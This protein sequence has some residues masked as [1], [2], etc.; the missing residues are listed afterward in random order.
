[1]GEIKEIGWRNNEPISFNAQTDFISRSQSSVH[2]THTNFHTQ[3]C[4]NDREVSTTAQPTSVSYATS[5]AIGSHDQYYN[6]N[7]PKL[8]SYQKAQMIPG[9][10]LPLV[11]DKTKLPEKKSLSLSDNESHQS[12][13]RRAC[14]VHLNEQYQIDHYLLSQ[15]RATKFLVKVRT[16]ISPGRYMTKLELHCS[17]YICIDSYVTVVHQ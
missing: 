1:M 7:F 10:T 6:A 12:L 5:V 3:P 8:Q 2:S 11:Q 16:E 14:L 9:N 4:I 17:R 15:P 13:S